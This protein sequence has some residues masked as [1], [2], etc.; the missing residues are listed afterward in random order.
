VKQKPK[1]R[2]G[3]GTYAGIV[4]TKMRSI[5][6]PTGHP[7]SLRDLADAVD[8]SYEHIRKIVTGKPVVS[9]ELNQKICEVL[10][11]DRE[12]M[13]EIAKGEKV[14]RRYGRVPLAP[15]P[16]P[17]ASAIVEMWDQLEEADQA[18]LSRFAEDLVAGS[19]S[20]TAESPRR[21]G[22][23]TEAGQPQPGDAPAD[24]ASVDLRSGV[25]EGEDVAGEGR[26][27]LRL[28]LCGGTE[29]RIPIGDGERRRLYPELQR[30]PFQYPAIEFAV[31]DSLDGR[32]YALN[33]HQVQAWLFSADPV[34]SS[35]QTACEVHLHPAGGRGVLVFDVEADTPND[36]DEVGYLNYVFYMLETCV[37]ATDSLPF[38]TASGDK[39]FFQ[40]GQV[41]VLSAPIAAIGVEEVEAD[42]I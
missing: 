15:L 17:G 2:P 20:G 1:S 7:I 29:I 3:R 22:G 8:Y 23:A 6:N 14:I 11:L 9:P 36:F 31:F 26:W 24:A 40:P 27:T 21:A 35:S 37:D 25:E 16:S 5:E 28:H 34:P 10:G 13:M 33:R 32:R 39:A 4:R 19:A 30:S 18:R 12:Q 38:R 42:E 41:A